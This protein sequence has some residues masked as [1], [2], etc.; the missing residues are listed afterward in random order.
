MKNLLFATMTLMIAYSAFA[1]DSNNILNHYLKVK[2]ALVESDG[3]QASVAAHSLQSSI[4]EDA[5]LSKD[6]DL[7]NA[8]DKFVKA[9]NLEQQRSQFNALSTTLWKDIK[10]D[11]NI[12]RSV[13]YQ[14]C[15]MK[16]AYW[17]SKEK[18]IENP[19]YGAAMLSCGKVVE[20]KK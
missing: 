17:L 19:Y 13:Y 2:N 12:S 3:K 4:K 15:P 8:I 11:Q 10:D 1:Q 18:E 20:E 5:V 16:K 7:V 9:K 14:Y 6:T